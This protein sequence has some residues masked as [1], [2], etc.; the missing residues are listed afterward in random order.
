MKRLPRPRAQ[1]RKDLQR[2]LT[3]SELRRHATTIDDACKQA[4]EYTRSSPRL[5][6]MR[7]KVRSE[8]VRKFFVGL[9]DR[10]RASVDEIKRGVRRGLDQ[11]TANTCQ[12]CGFSGARESLDHFLEKARFPELSLFTPN[13]IPCCFR[14]N[15][16][17]GRSPF[18]PDGTRQLLHFYDD[19]VDSMPDVLIANV[20]LINNGVPVANYSIGPSAHPLVDVYRNHFDVLGLAA[21]YQDEAS[22]QLLV[23]RGEVAQAMPVTRQQVTIQLLGRAESQT[24]VYGRNH[25]L[26]ALYRGLASSPQALKWLIP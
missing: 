23:I 16:H 5:H 24:Q 22:I 15:N 2:A 8:S 3:P 6:L 4:H 25:Y 26:A 14:C 12:Y 18:A 13:L 19:D 17:G 20:K 21:L 7:T 9:Y 10:K 11:V 1:Y